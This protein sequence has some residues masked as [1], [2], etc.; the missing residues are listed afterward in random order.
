MKKILVSLILFTVVFA[1]VAKAQVVDTT[2][3][4]ALQVQLDTLIQKL[5]LLQQ[6]LALL[7]RV[8][9]LQNDL[10]AQLQAQANAPQQQNIQAP[11]PAPA[12]E[13]VNTPV[14]TSTPQ[15]ATTTPPVP[16][17]YNPTLSLTS[18]GGFISWSV[19]NP[20]ESF[21]CKLNG[22]SVSQEGSA[23][24]MGSDASFTLECLGRVTGIKLSKTI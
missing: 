17:V 21:N 16:V 22:T 11:S 14:P 24:I 12:P 2:S 15:V 19:Q 18:E 1:N 6:I 13:I 10:K 5:D 7:Q 3:Q 23:P 4:T 8:E 9:A 20:K